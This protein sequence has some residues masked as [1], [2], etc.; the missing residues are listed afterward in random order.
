MEFTF[1]VPGKT[2][3]L[4]EYAVLR[5]APALIMCHDPSYVFRVSHQKREGLISLQE[6]FHPESPAGYLV[7]HSALREAQIFLSCQHEYGQGGFGLS[8]AEFWMAHQLLRLMDRSGQRDFLSAASLQLDVDHL[9][10]LQTYWRVFDA[11]KRN[12]PSGAD[13]QA[14]SKGGLCYVDQKQSVLQSMHWP[15]QD[16][17]LLVIPTGKK[18]K[19]HQHLQNM[20]QMDLGDLV[21]LSET[22]LTVLKQGDQGI[23]V[24]LVQQYGQL[25]EQKGLLAPA[26]KELMGSLR[27]ISGVLAV[28]GCGAMGADSMLSVVETAQKEQI[29]A[30]LH[31]QGFRVFDHFGQGG[32]IS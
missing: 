23:F 10:L 13:L 29:V 15:F 7:H 20:Q 17:C 31:G 8:T 9:D 6:F 22:I 32:F 11:Q 1:Q 14:Q 27:Q 18:L 16:L 26:T 25:L 3:L 5:S 19:T 24:A 2:F 4:G 12:R 21:R 28:K 30:K